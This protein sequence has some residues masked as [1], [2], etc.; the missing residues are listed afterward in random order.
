MLL[1]L[2]EPNDSSKQISTAMENAVDSLT[3]SERREVDKAHRQMEMKIQEI[4]TGTYVQ[5]FMTIVGQM[6]NGRDKTNLMLSIANVLNSVA[7]TQETIQK[8]KKQ[9]AE[10]LHLV[11]YIILPCIISSFV[12]GV[13]YVGLKEVKN[14]MSDSLVMDICYDTVARV[15][16]SYIPWRPE[17]PEHKITRNTYLCMAYMFLTGSFQPIVEFMG[18]L[19]GKSADAAIMTFSLCLFIVLYGIIILRAKAS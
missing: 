2:G 1:T 4:P 13:T 18:K 5:Q 12:S 16:A 17:I 11:S 3:P 6:E 15:P 7:M 19:S 14:I 9:R 8:T 10:T